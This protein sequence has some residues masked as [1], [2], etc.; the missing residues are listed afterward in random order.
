MATTV[1]NLRAI[2]IKVS[3]VDGHGDAPSNLPRGPTNFLSTYAQTASRSASV[4]VLK[5]RSQNADTPAE[6]PAGGTAKRKPPAC[7][8]LPT[9]DAL[10]AQQTGFRCRM[11]A[12]PKRDGAGQERVII[13]P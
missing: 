12:V 10:H 7:T 13:E 3:G 9:N 11:F 8:S 6:L 4:S 5:H 1:G 2:S